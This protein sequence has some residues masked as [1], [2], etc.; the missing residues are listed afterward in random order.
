[1]SGRLLGAHRREL[2]VEAE[3][4]ELAS[5]GLVRQ[6]LGQTGFEVELLFAQAPVVRHVERAVEAEGACWNEHSAQ[7]KNIHS[8]ITETNLWTCV[9]KLSPTCG[10]PSKTQP[11]LARGAPWLRMWWV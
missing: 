11:L 1:M 7:E 2:T 8:I 4:L 3:R 10:S 5:V 9:L 6:R